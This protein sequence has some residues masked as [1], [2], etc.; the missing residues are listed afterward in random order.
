MDGR[1]MLNMRDDRGGSRAVFTTADMGKSWQE[2][3]TNR[4]A[5]I[6]P[7]CMASLIRFNKDWLFFSNPEATDGRY[8]ITVKASKD[9]GLT[10]ANSHQVLLDDQKGW[11]YSCMTK[12]DEK[13]L[14]ILY[15]SSQAHMT[16]QILPIS[17]IIS[18][19]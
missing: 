13:N 2:H 14:G 10:W 8:N 7:I 6:E 17:E 11:G 12:I 18:I 4:N 19:E 5:L 16:F 15:E 3:P 1:L 9:E